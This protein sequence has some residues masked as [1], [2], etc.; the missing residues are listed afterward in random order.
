MEFLIEE[1]IKRLEEMYSKGNDSYKQERQSQAL[2]AER[3]SKAAEKKRKK[4]G[5]CK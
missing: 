3:H 2:D 1:I 4:D 5:C